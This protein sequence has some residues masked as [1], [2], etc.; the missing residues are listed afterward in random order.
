MAELWFNILYQLSV[1]LSV[2][3]FRLIFIF[4]QIMWEKGADVEVSSYRTQNQNHGSLSFI[5][6]GSEA[7]TLQIDNVQVKDSGYYWCKVW[8]KNI[9]KSQKSVLLIVNATGKLLND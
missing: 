5:Q 6:T 3:E 8:Q 4:K 2:T 9:I 7:Y 1:S